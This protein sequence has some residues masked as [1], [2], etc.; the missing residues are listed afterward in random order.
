LPGRTADLSQLRARGTE[1]SNQLIS[2]TGR[3]DRLA[4]ELRRGMEGADRVGIEERI[5][6]LDKRILQLETD[7]AENGRQ[8]AQQAIAGT[9]GGRGGGFGGGGFGGTMNRPPNEFGR[10]NS[11]QVSALSGLFMLTV[12]A[13]LA[14][15][16]ARAIW[17]RANRPA[18]PPGWNDAASRMHNL[19]EAV[20]TIAVEMERVS[21]GQRYLTRVLTERAIGP[22]QWAPAEPFPLPERERVPIRRDER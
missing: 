13:P 18:A 1:L 4:Q 15:A 19:E 21:E 6:L 8:L 16:Y 17:K 9:P 3:R 20:D 12:L 7:I 2:A 5:K 11:N 22:G 14:F 10:F